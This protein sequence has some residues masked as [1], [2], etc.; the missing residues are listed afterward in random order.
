GPGQYVKPDNPDPLFTIA[1]LS[2]VWMLADIY[3]TDVPLIKVGQPVEVHVTAYPNE[4]FT[5]RIEYIGASVDPNTHRVAG[6]SVVENRGQR[7]KPDMFASFRI[8]TH[9]ETQS[10]AI[11]LSAIVHDGEKTSVW[12]QQSANQFARRDISPGLEQGGYVQ[13]LSGLQQGE[14]VV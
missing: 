8:V 3:E 4:P 2:S 13:V 1:N 11:P 9:S 14:K 10:L 5:A 6:R 7:L 12:V